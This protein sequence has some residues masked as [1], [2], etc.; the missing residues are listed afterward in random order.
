MID[1]SYTRTLNLL[2]ERKSE[3]EKLAEE[4]LNQDALDAN[5]RY[6]YG[7][8]L[9]GS[10]LVG[11]TTITAPV[12][13]SR[14]RLLRKSRSISASRRSRSTSSCSSLACAPRTS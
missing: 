14:S 12:G 13:G 7:K 6:D 5:L 3:V 1:E 11:A 8:A 4:L 2:R 9:F 10:A